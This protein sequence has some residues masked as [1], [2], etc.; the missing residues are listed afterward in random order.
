MTKQEAASV[1]ELLHGVGM[2]HYEVA[3]LCGCTVREL[4]QLSVKVMSFKWDNWQNNN[5]TLTRQ[6]KMNWPEELARISN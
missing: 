5:I 2:S 4:E 1:L 3:S 6:S